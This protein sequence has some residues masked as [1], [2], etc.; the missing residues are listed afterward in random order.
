MNIGHQILFNSKHFLHSII[1]MAVATIFIP[2]KAQA[3]GVIL[4]KSHPSES[5]QFWRVFPFS[6]SETWPYNFNLTL[7]NGQQHSF[8]KT[9]TGAIFEEPKWNELIITS[10]ADWQKLEQQKSQL[11]ESLGKFPQLKSWAE[12]LASKFEKILDKTSPNT[13]IYRGRVFSRDEYNKLR[14]LDA[15]SNSGSLGKGV[16]SELTIG[17]VELR[18]VKLKSFNGTRVSLVHSNG[19]QGYNLA[20]LKEAEVSSLSKAFPEF[21]EHV[22]E[23]TVIKSDVSKSSNAPSDGTK[24]DKTERNSIDMIPINGSSAQTVNTLPFSGSKKG[25]WPL[26]STA[27]NSVIPPIKPWASDQ[28]RK[29]SK[30]AADTQIPKL[31]EAQKVVELSNRIRGLRLKVEGRAISNQCKM[32]KVQ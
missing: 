8:L 17:S 24:E 29:T 25:G 32:L 30:S 13:V 11:L 28:N 18:D 1:S 16:V 21:A 12:S 2:S 5:A 6:K 15:P 9:E 26:D 3:D 7:L 23:L 14:G 31:S 4:V 27:I 20:D 10:D 19:I 22:K